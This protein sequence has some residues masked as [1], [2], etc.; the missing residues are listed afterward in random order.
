MNRGRLA[1]ERVGLESGRWQHAQSLHDEPQTDMGL[2]EWITQYL[3]GGAN[4]L[5]MDGHVEWIKYPGPFPT[6]R[7]WATLVDQM[8]I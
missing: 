8:G 5:Y 1:R 3:P 2:K 7:A 6:N 4:V